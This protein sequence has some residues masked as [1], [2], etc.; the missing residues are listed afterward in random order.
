MFYIYLDQR[1]LINLAEGRDEA[2][3]IRLYQE[4]AAS[5]IQIVLSLMHVV[6]TWK[7][8]DTQA[9]QNLAAY[10]DSISPI[11][12]LFR[13]AL[14]REE[15]L[16][17]FFLFRGEKVATLIEESHT[18]VCA[19]YPLSVGNHKTFSPFR[20]SVMETLS[21]SS[22]VRLS[23]AY[24]NS[25][26]QM[27]TL[28]EKDPRI[29]KMVAEVHDCYPDWS[30]DVKLKIIRELPGK[31][32]WLLENARSALRDLD[33]KDATIE[34]FVKSLDI[35]TCPSIYVYLRIK[36]AITKDKAP[37]PYPSE[38]VDIVHVSAIPYVD[39]FSTDKRIWDY[40]RRCK[41]YKQIFPEG[42]TRLARAFKSLADI[43]SSIGAN[44]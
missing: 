9:K 14:F 31:S 35:T 40:V 19:C 12:L 38:M 1:D 32:K 30:M 36:D 25:F 33:I 7:Y 23:E 29:V 43:M 39:A 44:Y 20:K 11:W 8:A 16:R 3:K 22:T 13:S 17:A 5:H 37:K 6:E 34:Q 10:A 2:L 28:F 42:Y 26:A 18:K 21:P 27:L 15:M 4:I 24:D 41:I